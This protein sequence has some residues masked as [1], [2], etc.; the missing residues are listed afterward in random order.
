MDLRGGCSHPAGFPGEGYGTPL[1]GRR[2][3]WN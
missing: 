2:L 1:T 3:V